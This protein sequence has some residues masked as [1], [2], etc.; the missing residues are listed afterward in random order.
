[1]VDRA[2]NGF[3]TDFLHVHYYFKHSFY[4][5]NVADVL[6]NIG[7]FLLLFQYKSFNETV[8]NAFNPSEVKG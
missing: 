1:I 7:V 4:V 8:N 6:V 3:V 2:L 5:F